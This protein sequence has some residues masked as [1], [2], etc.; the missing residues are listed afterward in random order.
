MLFRMFF[1]QKSGNCEIWYESEY[2]K[3]ISG[4]SEKPFHE[5]AKRSCSGIYFKV[6]FLIWTMFCVIL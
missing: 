1:Y 4:I 2:E 5:K 3:D 6:S